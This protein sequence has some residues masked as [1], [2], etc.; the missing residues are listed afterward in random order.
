MSLSAWLSEA[1][2]RAN[3]VDEGLRAV[4]EWEKENGRLMP[5][6]VTVLGNPA[7]NDDH[8]GL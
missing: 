8:A 3:K 4:R 2:F 1:A 7:E 6:R 5:L